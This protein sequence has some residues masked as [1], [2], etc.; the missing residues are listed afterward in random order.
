MHKVV[1]RSSGMT[2]FARLPWKDGKAQIVCRGWYAIAVPAPL[3]QPLECK[4][5]WAYGVSTPRLA[6]LALGY[7]MSEYVMRLQSLGITSSISQ[8]GYLISSV[9]H[10]SQP[11]AHDDGD[12]PRPDIP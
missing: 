5:C 7:T 4:R 2:H 12:E 11:D 6:L 10:E 3:A 9:P 8:E 1:V